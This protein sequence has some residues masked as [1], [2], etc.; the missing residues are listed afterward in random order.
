[1]TAAR[2]DIQPTLSD[3]MRFGR[4]ETVT[5][6]PPR[7]IVRYGD[8]DD[9]DGDAMT[10]P[11]RWINARAGETRKWSPPSADEEVL[12]LCPDGQYGNAVAITGLTNDD[13]PPPGT[14]PGDV[15]EYADGARLSY[16]P[17]AHILSAILPDAATA[18][19]VA[20]GGI[21]LRGNVTIEGALSVSQG[22]VASDD[23]VASGI[24]LTGH[25]HGGV[26][27]GSAKTAVPE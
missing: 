6:D 13:F 27:S 25:R 4:I 12:L 9:P 19:I 14:G 15:T 26:Q 20:S 11:I 7:C 16:D 17:V 23:V 10:P 1:M 3:L 18:T 5:F 8:P 2:E 22:V 24:S 21:T